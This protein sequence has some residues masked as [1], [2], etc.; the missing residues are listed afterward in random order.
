[1]PATSSI[2]YHSHLLSTKDYVRAYCDPPRMERYCREC[3]NWGRCWTCPPFDED[4]IGKLN[5][6]EHTLI[7]GIKRVTPSPEGVSLDTSTIAKRN[8]LLIRD[9]WKVTKPIIARWQQALPESFVFSGTFSCPCK[10]KDCTRIRG[11]K[12]RYPQEMHPS[13]EA[14]GFD[15]AKTSHDLLGIDLQWGDGNTPPPYLVLVVAFLFNGNPETIDYKQLNA[16]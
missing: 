12:C 5:N 14:V 11:E 13:L 9:S 4:L 1:M 3:P 6:Y 16:L 15:V 2:S 10:V 7:L 8:F